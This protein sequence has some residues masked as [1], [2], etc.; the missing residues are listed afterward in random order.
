MS[1]TSP[2]SPS[3]RRTPS[4]TSTTTS[5]TERTRSPLEQDSASTASSFTGDATSVENVS[6]ASSI[7]SESPIS[8]ESLFTRT[9]LGP[10]DVSTYF[11]SAE[12]FQGLAN[13]VYEA[14][15]NQ[16][17]L[18][19]AAGTP[20]HAVSTFLQKYPQFSE[21]LTNLDALLK[22]E[23]K[24]GLQ[25]ILHSPVSDSNKRTYQELWNDLLQDPQDV[26]AKQIHKLLDTLTQR[27]IM[28]FGALALS[29]VAAG[30][31]A[32]LVSPL[33]GALLG[34]AFLF[35]ASTSPIVNFPKN[36]DFTW[37]REYKELLNMIN[38]AQQPAQGQDL[39]LDK[40]DKDALR[41]ILNLADSY[42]GPVGFYG[43]FASY[44]LR[45]ELTYFLAHREILKLYSALTTCVARN[46]PL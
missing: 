11:S 38:N 15:C 19:Q 33:L 24:G 41:T 46:A 44:H 32:G 1:T 6:T 26:D 5:T 35:L 9:R 2:S 8:S 4:P 18:N 22:D 27:Q 25:E 7:S 31:T 40:D 29:M 3:A 13:T 39:P 23:N 14:G 34:V 16:D 28:F 37:G 20:Q 45:K 36:K 10:S 30:L 21:F 42:Q 12:G 17:G 43:I